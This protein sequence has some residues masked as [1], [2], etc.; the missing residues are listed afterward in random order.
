M[1]TYTKPMLSLEVLVNE[2]NRSA[3]E[4]ASPANN[5]RTHADIFSTLTEY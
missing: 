1:L 2:R 3:G 4:S 5:S